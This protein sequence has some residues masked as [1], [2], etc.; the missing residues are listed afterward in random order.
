MSYKKL[1]GRIKEIYENQKCFAD[2]MDMNAASL[3]AKLNNKAP[4]RREEIEK[5]CVLLNIPLEQV[6]LYFFTPK[7]EISQHEC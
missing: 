1:R 6:Y 4:W 3:S 7:V 2:A 5:A